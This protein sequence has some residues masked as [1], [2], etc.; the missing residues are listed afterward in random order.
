MSFSAK[1]LRVRRVMRTSLIEYV[2]L[3]GNCQIGNYSKHWIA[4]KLHGMALEIFHGKYLQIR[5][6]AAAFLKASI[7]PESTQLQAVSM[8]SKVSNSVMAVISVRAFY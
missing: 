8:P 1:S 2:I 4:L 7:C 6:N 5:Q 3:G